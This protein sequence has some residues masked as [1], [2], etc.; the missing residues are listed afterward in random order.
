MPDLLRLPLRAAALA[1]APTRFAVKTVW[2]L[3]HPGDADERPPAAT[4]PV[5]EP[6]PTAPP[7]TRPQPRRPPPSPKAAR[8]AARHEP[9]RGQAAALRERQR[10]RE[11]AA[12]GPGPGPEITVAEP[13][14]GYEQMGEEAILDRL[15]GAD[16][17]VRAAVRLYESV[18]A[19][20]TQVL[21]ATEEPAPS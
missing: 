1:L 11:Q 2:G 5:P 18:N 21:Y 20:R 14:S 19:G 13:W 15:V 10:E 8:R 4:A 16:Q 12:G 9:T 6:A 3:L 17:A 7:Q